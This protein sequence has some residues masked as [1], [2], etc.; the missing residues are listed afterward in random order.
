MAVLL[1]L[2]GEAGP[3]YTGVGGGSWVSGGVGEYRRRVL[4]YM[5]EYRGLEML[6][7]PWPPG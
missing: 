5:A 6:R 2:M 3:G 4:R 1:T 7:L